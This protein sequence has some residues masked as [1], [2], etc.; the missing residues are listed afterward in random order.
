MSLYTFLI[1][2]GKWRLIHVSKQ[3][4]GKIKSALD[5]LQTKE[6]VR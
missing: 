2:S 5:S 4:M 3:D 6:E 1:I